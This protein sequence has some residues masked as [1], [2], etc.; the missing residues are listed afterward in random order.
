MTDVGPHCS[1][2]LRHSSFPD[3]PH[4]LDFLTDR[5]GIVIGINYH[6]NVRSFQKIPACR[7][8]SDRG[9]V[10][11]NNYFQNPNSMPSLGFIWVDLLPSCRI[12]SLTMS[13]LG[14]CSEAHCCC[15][16]IRDASDG[17]KVAGDP[18]IESTRSFKVMHNV[19][20]YTELQ[21]RKSA[22]K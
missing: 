13:R 4:T 2:W 14:I 9:A 3:E 1:L 18:E 6:L 7:Q 17:S 12:S 10:C 15:L 5:L 11:V 20:N 21:C 22:S 8:S 16:S 19:R